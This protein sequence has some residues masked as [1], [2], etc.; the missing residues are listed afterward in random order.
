METVGTH[1]ETLV[2]FL[3]AIRATEQT[4]K[5]R[6]FR[7]HGKSKKV[8]VTVNQVMMIVLIVKGYMT[9]KFKRNGLVNKE[10]A[11]PAV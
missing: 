2:I 4:G 7:D 9:W 3:K 6:T 5:S 10:N 1:A 11:T 8:D